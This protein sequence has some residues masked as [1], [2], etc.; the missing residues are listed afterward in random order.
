MNLIISAFL[1]VLASVA[2]VSLFFGNSFSS[3][4]VGVSSSRLS[5]ELRGRLA[6][7]ESRP[8]YVGALPRARTRIGGVESLGIELTAVSAIAIDAETGEVLFQKNQDK[9]W[10]TASLAK[11][12]TALQVADRGISG[13][14]QIALEES[15]EGEG[16]I[17]Y[18]IPGERV[19]EQELFQAMLVGSANSAAVALARGSG[20]IAEFVIAMNERAR[21]LGLSATHFVDPTGLDPRNVSTARNVALLARVAFA[22]EA[23]RTA[24]SASSVTVHPAGGS[25]REIR[26]TNA[27][28]SGFLNKP[29]YAIVAGKTGHLDESRYNLALELRRDG[30]NVIIVILGSETAERRFQEAKALAAWLFNDFR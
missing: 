24:A 27:L 3:S 25:P 28:L 20:S 29:P 30:R 17:P 1:G 7:A 21:A 13:E 26:S 12:M 22:E 14:A 18:F 8:V 4:A 16:G 9:V 23:L 10:P 19:S 5:G 2:A 11:L 6:P 15:D